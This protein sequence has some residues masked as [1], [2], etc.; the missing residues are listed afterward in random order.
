[1]FS[2]KINGNGIISKNKG[3]GYHSSLS[4]VSG[5]ESE[6][7]R[8]DGFFCLLWALSA[9]LSRLEI[10]GTLEFIL[11]FDFPFSTVLTMYP[12]LVLQIVVCESGWVLAL[13]ASVFIAGELLFGSC[14]D[15]FLFDAKG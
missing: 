2:I 9:I 3:F 1:M 10:S 12:P 4:E 14:G 15:G 7:K 6:G 8:W 11:G 13:L 5:V